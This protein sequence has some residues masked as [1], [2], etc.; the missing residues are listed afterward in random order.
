MNK[1]EIKLFEAF[2]GI[3]SQYKALKNIGNKMNW[4]VNCVGIIEWFI[5]AI[6]SYVELYSQKTKDNSIN[7]ERERE[8]EREAQRHIT[9]F[10]F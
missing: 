7:V 3:G 4:E 8:R 2:A 10:G 6:C 5:P 9:E 1:K